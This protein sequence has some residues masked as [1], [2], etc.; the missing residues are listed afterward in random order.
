M[1]KNSIIT[2]LS[3]CFVFT[4]C[5]HHVATTTASTPSKKGT[6][7]VSSPPCIIYKTRTDYSMYVP[8]MLSADKSKVES[9]PD[10]K[11]IYYQG[12]FA[13][14]TLLVNGYL[15]DNRGI[16][17]QV[18]FMWYTYEEYSK[19]P[20]TPHPTDLMS[21]IQDKDPLVEMYQCGQRSQYTNIEQELNDII[22]SGKLST[23]KKLK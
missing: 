6:V 8:V 11:D 9:Y 20:S 15:L 22:K 2:L 7:A 21:L 19:L 12:K 5:S 23:C 18:A 17:P 10:I 1:R 4:S 13:L 16:G 3:A 14:P